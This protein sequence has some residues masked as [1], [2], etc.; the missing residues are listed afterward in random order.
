[1]ARRGPKRRPEKAE[2]WRLL[3][4]GVGTF[5]ACRLVGTGRKTGYRWR[6]ENG[7]SPPARHLA[8]AAVTP[9]R[10]RG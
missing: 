8:R 6:A 1:M 2:Y 5:E 9:P 10:R 7:G 3:Q 4:S